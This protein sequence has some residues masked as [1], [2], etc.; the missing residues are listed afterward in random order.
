MAGR[1]CPHC[2]AGAETDWAFCQACGRKLPAAV[3]GAMDQRD[4]RIASIWVRAGRDI[5]AGDLG[6]AEGAAASLM[7]LGC[8]AGDVHA[9]QGAIALRR[10]NVEESRALLDKAAEESPTPPLCG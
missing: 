4:E 9:L 1:F 3:A 7:D 5:D 10:G 8:D 2:A 6:S